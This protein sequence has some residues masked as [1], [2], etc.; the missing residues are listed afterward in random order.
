MKRTIIIGPYR[1]NTVEAMMRNVRMGREAAVKLLQ[2][3][4]APYCPWL[5]LEYLMHA[6]IDVKTFQKVTHAWLEVSESCLMLPGWL[7]SEGAL[8]DAKKAMEL[9]L[10][11][12]KYEDG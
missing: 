10:D 9:G 8:K 4:Q 7:K 11:V 1:A 12:I 5:D 6:D 3:G 2:Y